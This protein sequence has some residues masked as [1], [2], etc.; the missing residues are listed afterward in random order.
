[1]QDNQSGG[2]DGA[3]AIEQAES[4]QA[5]DD[6]P[7]TVDVTTSPRDSEPASQHPWPPPPT[8]PPGGVSV[9][10]AVAVEF[11]VGSMHPTEAINVPDHEPRYAYPAALPAGAIPVDDAEPWSR[12]RVV[13]AAGAIGAVA[14]AAATVGVIGLGDES[15]S[16]NA[17]AL[18]Q[19]EAN[20]ASRSSIAEGSVGIGAASASAAEPIPPATPSAPAG[21]PV[22]PPTSPG[23]VPSPPAVPPRPSELKATY[24][25]VRRTG[26]AKYTGQVTI[27]NVGD[28]TAVGWRVVITLPGKAQATSASGVDFE[29]L[30]T[31]VAFTPRV[32]TRTIGSGESLRFTFE[33]RMSKAGQPTGCFI[34]D[35]PCQ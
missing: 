5:P 3:A 20:S 27:S 7:S 29:Q 35:L 1:M 31:S 28:A 34:N 16:Q 2:P 21:P 26:A 14:L 4:E 9:G 33:V 6:E 10:S 22:R 8:S 19:R 13:M 11:Q 24:L 18:P 25:T 15:Q 32:D 12:R 30:G 17:G 23:A